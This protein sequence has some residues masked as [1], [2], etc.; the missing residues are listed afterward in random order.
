MDLG[1]GLD[2]DDIFDN[3]HGRTKELCKDPYSVRLCPELV[4]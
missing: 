4:R 3:C 1:L 2:S